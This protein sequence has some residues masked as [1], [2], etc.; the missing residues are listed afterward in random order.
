MLIAFTLPS[1]SFEKDL[2][3]IKVPNMPM[4]AISYVA[5]VHNSKVY[6][7]ASSVD[8]RG[9]RISPILV[10]S[11][12]EYKWSILPQQRGSAA[13]AVV[14]N[15]VTLI[16]GQD[17][18]TYWYTNTPSTWYEE[19]VR[20]KQVLPPMP[21][22]RSRPAVISHDNLLLVTGG[23]AENGFT[24]LNT[25]DVLDLSTMKWTFPERLNL[26]VPL[27][28]HHLVLCGEYLYLVGGATMCPVQSPAHANSWAWRAKWSD[29]KQTAAPQLSQPQRGTWTRIADPP[30]LFP[31]A[32]SC[33]GALYTVGG[34]ARD[35]KPVSIVHSYIPARNQW[36]SV[37]NMSV[38]RYFHCAVPL[39]SNTIF[40]AGGQVIHNGEAFFSP[41][42]EL[43]VL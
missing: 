25:T 41:L 40:V 43:L 22:G 32:V 18:L 29:V 24:V 17:I 38:G 26:P 34:I 3:S 27:W 36:V 37:G 21:T 7:R 10:Y 14:N 8:E 39:N 33:G 23:L 1:F 20:W 16:G 19:E 5:T 12:R 9:A 42:A 11:T 30:T 2:R 31:T 6:I 13:I 28:Q 35:D 15:H 4:G